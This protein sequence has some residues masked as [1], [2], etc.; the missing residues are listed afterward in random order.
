VVCTEA[1]PDPL[2]RTDQAERLPD[3]NPSAYTVPAAAAL[4]MGVTA[5]VPATR[6]RTSARESRR[7]R[8]PPV[9]AL[10][11]DLPSCHVRVGSGFS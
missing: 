1:V 7:L 11:I 4:G 5:A 2:A 3:S 9:V 6:T 8:G 10:A